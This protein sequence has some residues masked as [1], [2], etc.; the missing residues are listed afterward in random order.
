MLPLKNRAK[1][2]TVWEEEYRVKLPEKGIRWLEGYAEPEKKPD[3][4][5]L[6]HGNIRDITERKE[7]ENKL[8]EQQGKIIKQKDRM[9]VYIRRYRCWYLGMECTNR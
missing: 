9:E 7:R 1:N 5:V 8:Q 2:L 4:S 3:G 6:W